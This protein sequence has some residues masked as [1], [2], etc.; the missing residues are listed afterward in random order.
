MKMI[1]AFLILVMS[2]STFASTG[3]TR[4]FVFDGSQNSV[5]LLLRGEKTHT[6]YRYEQR[7]SICY[8]TEI[9]GYRTVCHSPAGEA[10]NKVLPP[11]PHRPGPAPIPPRPPVCHTEPIYRT[12]SYPCMQ[13][14]RI[15]YEVKDYDTEAHVVLNV[16]KLPEAL[17]TGETF[18]VT[19]FGEEVTL[20]AS[21]SKKYFLVLNSKNI[22]TQLAGSVKF[23]DATYNVELIE[24]APVTRALRMNKISMKTGALTF[25]VGPVTKTENLGFSVRVD[26]APILGGNTT[27]F[28][29]ELTLD[30]LKISAMNSGS[31]ITVDLGA[32]GVQMGGGRH[33]VTAKAFLK[34]NGALLNGA[35]FGD[36][37]VGRTL[38]LKR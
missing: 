7:P 37:E 27:I 14:V 12:V 11:P 1:L 35:Q 29:R 4:T 20:E 38:I 22:S 23:I 15:A 32:L 21:G 33:L 13:T 26:K 28:S 18:K 34:V 30:E 3:E 25:D 36:L 10:V 19:L 8:R 24:A 17:T 6:E 31:L 16:A 2:L 9:V 5:E